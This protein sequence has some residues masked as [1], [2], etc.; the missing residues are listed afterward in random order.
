MK[1]R[2]WLLLLVLLCPM[3]Q[4]S[5]ADKVF[6]QAMPAGE[7]APV[8]LAVAQ[9]QAGAVDEAPRKFSGRITE[10]CQQK[11]CWVM[12]EDDGAVARV[13]MKDHSFAVPGEARGA[14]IVFGTLSRKTL[15]AATAKHLAED[16]G[17]QE[18]VPADEYRIEA[19]SVQLIEG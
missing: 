13:M 4:A 1:M 9:L 19:L 3:V 6:G 14:A 17:E 11:G 15:D 7:A 10:V 12:L 18:P 8:A 5:E 2:T 16:A